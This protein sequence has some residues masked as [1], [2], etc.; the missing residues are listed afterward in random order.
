MWLP[1]VAGGAVSEQTETTGSLP[2]SIVS[3]RT[4]QRPKKEYC[5]FLQA[6]LDCAPD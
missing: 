1:T 6:Q 3:N 5:K 4:K 2:L